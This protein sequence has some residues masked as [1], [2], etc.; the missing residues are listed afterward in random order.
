MG[1]EQKGEDDTGDPQWQQQQQWQ[2]Q[3][4]WQ[5]QEGYAEEGTGGGGAGGLVN[6][7]QEAMQEKQEGGAA[8]RAGGW[9]ISILSFSCLMMVCAFV[10]KPC[11]SFGDQFSTSIPSSCI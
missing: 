11:R 5:Q 10:L 8:D 1:G 7:K 9:S 2:E 4:Q 3:Q 6:E